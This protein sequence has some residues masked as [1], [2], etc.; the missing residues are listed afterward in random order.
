MLAATAAAIAVRYKSYTPE[1]PT[2]TTFVGY[3]GV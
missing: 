3:S 1:Y 2:E